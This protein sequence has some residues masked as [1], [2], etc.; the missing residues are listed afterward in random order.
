MGEAGLWW[1]MR[2]KGNSRAEERD[3]TRPAPNQARASFLLKLGAAVSI[4]SA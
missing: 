1:W 3:W 2:A 4:V